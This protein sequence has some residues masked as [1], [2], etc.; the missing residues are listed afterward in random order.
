V[1]AY[2]ARFTRF[3]TDLRLAVLLQECE[4]TLL[5][6]LALLLTC[7]WRYCCKS[8]SILPSSDGARE[9]ML[10]ALVKK[11]KKKYMRTRMQ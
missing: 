4:H 3:T 9:A 1:R 6:L 10:L 8:A 11:K 7:A 2:L 5:A